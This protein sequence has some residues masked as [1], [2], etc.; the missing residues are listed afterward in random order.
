LREV[1]HQY[2]VVLENLWALHKMGEAKRRG[3]PLNRLR[4]PLVN[5]REFSLDF[6]YFVLSAYGLEPP[7]G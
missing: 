7:W 2:A 1:Y 3:L 4:R 6:G 5:V